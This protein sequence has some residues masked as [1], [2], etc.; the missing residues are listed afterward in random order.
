[1]VSVL[2]KPADVTKVALVMAKGGFALKDTPVF[3]N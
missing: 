3:N 2:Q 1:M